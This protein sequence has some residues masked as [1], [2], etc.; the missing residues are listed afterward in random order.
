MAQHLF[1]ESGYAVVVRRTERLTECEPMD[2]GS[3]VWVVPQQ[4]MVTEFRYSPKAICVSLLLRTDQ[5][6]DD[7]VRL[8]AGAFEDKFGTL[9]SGE[10]AARERFAFVF[11]DDPSTPPAEG[12]LE[13]FF[14]RV[15]RPVN[16]QRPGSLETAM[17]ALESPEAGSHFAGEVAKSAPI[18]PP[19]PS[20]RTPSSGYAKGVLDRL[21]SAFTGTQASIL[22]VSASLLGGT[23]FFFFRS[24]SHALKTAKV[25]LE[26]VIEEPV[27]PAIAARRPPPA[28]NAKRL[29]RRMLSLPA[30]TDEDRILLEEIDSLIL[31]LTTQ[32][33][34]KWSEAEDIIKKAQAIS[35]L[36]VKENLPALEIVRE[37]L[38][39]QLKQ[40]LLKSRSTSWH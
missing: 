22:L 40:A 33:D 5:A 36:A 6:G 7:A 21:G 9:P 32:S 23:L 24:R 10:F 11:P 39:D 20:D 34:V 31:Q 27:Q 28:A 18:A 13:I 30:N 29:S 1:Q 2:A 3:T 14:R 35:A 15:P 25:K 17:T 8:D 4:D 38:S 37:F 26:S 16:L 12:A 19:A